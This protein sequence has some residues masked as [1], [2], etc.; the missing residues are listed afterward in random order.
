MTHSV[1]KRLESSMPTQSR[2]SVQCTLAAALIT[3]Q[4]IQKPNK[5]II[6]KFTKR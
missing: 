1:I 6:F 2:L 5:I 4:T 3:H